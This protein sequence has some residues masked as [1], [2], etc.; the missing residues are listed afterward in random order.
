MSH[1]AFASLLQQ[2]T[3]G[4]CVYGCSGFS[5]ASRPVQHGALL[6]EKQQKKSM[7]QP[8]RAMSLSQHDWEGEVRHC[9]YHYCSTG[10]PE[11]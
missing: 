3:H 6:F 10:D 1:L 8:N 9:V 4:W 2:K 11:S 5:A 7:R